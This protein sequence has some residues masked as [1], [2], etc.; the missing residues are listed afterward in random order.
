M[1]GPV[2]P[3]AGDAPAGPALVRT[4]G[5]GPAAG[6]AWALALVAAAAAG[7]VAARPLPRWA[8]AALVAG[9]LLVRRPVLVLVG[10]ALLASAL[11]AR[12]LAGAAPTQPGPV[13]G[14]VLLLADPQERR[15]DTRVVVRYQG[16]HHEAWARES[17]AFA[18]GQRSAGEVV[19]V[20]GRVG[21]PPAGREQ[22]Y[23]RRH[24]VGRLQ[25]EAVTSWSPGAP[26]VRA[27]NRVRAT[28]L[29]GA[30]VLGP[31]RRALFAGLVLGDDRGQ[32]PV[33]V[34]DVDASGL[35][36]LLAVSG[37]NVA[38]VLAL[39]GPALRRLP[40]GARLAATLAV[41]GW[42]AVLTR[43]EPSVLRAV[44]MASVAAVA[45]ALGREASALRL[46]ALAVTGLLLVDPLL[47]WSTGFRLSVAATAGIVLLA[48]R[49]AARLPG[50]RWLAEPL[51]VVVAAQVG[52]APVAVPAFGGLPVASFPANVLVDPVAGLVTVWGLPAGLVAGLVPPMAGGLHLPTAAALGWLELVARTVGRCPLGALQ[53][54][55]VAVLVAA[56]GLAGVGRWWARSAGA[57]LAVAVLVAAALAG[58]PHV[59]HGAVLRGG[60]QLWQVPSGGTTTAVLVVDNVDAAALLTALR[61]AGV[62]RVD[63]VVLR[64]SA[65][66]RAT[67]ALPVLRR[68][69][70]R[71]LL[72][73]PGTPLAEAV[74]PTAGEA[75]AAGRLVVDVLAVGRRLDVRVSA[76][77]P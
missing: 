34:D 63:V 18:L 8:A 46:L 73:P 48:G 37:A 45:A 77:P 33:V 35:T 64:S 30:E 36:H 72:A 68:Y 50:P 62:R 69:P 14:T 38:F 70:P 9:A 49:V 31:A 67:A 12:A 71:L 5:S 59:L 15:G 4:R 60:G 7:A 13:D 44:A 20:R 52:V 10:V 19:A 47:V 39:A 43:G 42:F 75:F 56:L 28:L 76:V 58:G 41:V 61:S 3:I 1:V 32:D 21:P 23:A 17:A 53:L 25:V 2:P 57:A 51:G 6:D 54:P 11:G 16:R 29:E 40:A 24:L 66:A 74:A 55:H 27:A 26:A 22:A 65:P